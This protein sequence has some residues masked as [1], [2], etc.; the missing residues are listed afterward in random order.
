MKQYTFSVTNL[1]SKK[2]DIVRCTAANPEWAL[3]QVK[4][5]YEGYLVCDLYCDIDKPHAVL[6]EIDASSMTAADAAFLEWKT[7]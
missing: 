4:S 7:S 6:G 2:S 5:C 1:V 3:L